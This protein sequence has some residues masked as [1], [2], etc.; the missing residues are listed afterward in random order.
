MV[1]INMEAPEYFENVGAYSI[2]LGNTWRVLCA[3]LFAYVV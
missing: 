2:V 3:S 1:V